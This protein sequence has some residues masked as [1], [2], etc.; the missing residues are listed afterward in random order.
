MNMQ[1]DQH[2]VSQNEIIGM[3][4]SA[5]LAALEKSFGGDGNSDSATNSLGRLRIERENIEDSNGDILCP[6]GWFS[7]NTSEEGKVNGKYASMSRL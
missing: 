1:E 3:G 6:S 7:V 4:E 5:A 2:P